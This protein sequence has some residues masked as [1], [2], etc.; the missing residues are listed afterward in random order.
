MYYYEYL[1][2]INGHLHVSCTYNEI[3]LF[4]YKQHGPVTVVNS[5]KEWSG[6]NVWILTKERRPVTALHV[7]KSA[8]PSVEMAV[9]VICT[10]R[11]EGRR[12]CS[13]RQ[14][15]KPLLVLSLA[16][17]LGLAVLQRLDVLQMNSTAS[18]ELIPPWPS[19]SFLS[20][21]FSEHRQS[22]TLACCCQHILRHACSFI[23]Y[24]DNIMLSWCRVPLE[25]ALFCQ[26]SCLG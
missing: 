23:T 12:G 1:T 20:P 4:I 24:H 9:G 5:V 8:W 6:M 25:Q 26:C 14:Y 13:S 3:L 7:V 2:V 19:S 17:R 22:D 21:S 18:S 16:C 11:G 15:V 10:M